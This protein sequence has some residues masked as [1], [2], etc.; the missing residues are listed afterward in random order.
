ML[1]VHPSVSANRGSLGDRTPNVAAAPRVSVVIP[2]YN[3]VDMLVSCLRALQA[4]RVARADYEVVVVDD[5]STDGTRDALREWT[6]SAEMALRACSRANGGP[7]AARNDGIRLARG[8]LIA[9]VDDDCLPEPDWLQ[10]LIAALPPD[11]RCAGIGGRIVGESNVLVARYV[12]WRGLSEHQRS[13][14]G[15]NY[16]V[17]ANA[18][19]HK[20]CL[21]EVGGFDERFRSAGGEDPELARR[22]RARGYYLMATERALVVHR[23]RETLR[24]FVDM[25]MR[26]GRGA[27]VDAQLCGQSVPFPRAR[28]LAFVA[29]GIGVEARTCLTRGHAAPIDRLAYLVL[30]IVWQLA[31]A[32]AYA[33]CPPIHSREPAER[34]LEGPNFRR[35]F[36]PL[37]WPIWRVSVARNLL[38]AQLS[39]KRE[40][41]PRAVRWIVR[42]LRYAMG[43]A[44]IR[45]GRR[46]TAFSILAGMHQ[47]DALES[48]SRLAERLARQLVGD[49]SRG[50]NSPNLCRDYASTLQPPSW[51]EGYF[52]DPC[53]ILGRLALVIKPRTER[54]KGVLVLK[55]NYTFSHIARFFDIDRISSAYHIVLEP[56]W[57]GYCN[58]AI[59]QYCSVCA[60]VFVEA[61]EPR[62]AAFIRTLGANLVAVPIASNWWVDHRVFRPLP[63]TRKDT[64]VVMVAT[65]ARYKRHFQFFR[66]LRDLRR[67]GR[68]LRVSLIGYPGDLTRHDVADMAAFFGV[69]GPD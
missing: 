42:W 23:H 55:Y 32:R 12:D 54:E 22:L 4:Q 24:G 64:D 35:P 27:G 19:F 36:G 56:A 33:S 26:Y 8:A 43:R 5:G 61:A 58:L 31:Y 60:P 53:T 15:I 63:G 30:G 49:V 39:E 34:L 67:K 14:E 47:A 48:A 37:R 11:A 28:V 21:L 69:C 17:T 66:V 46:S 59:L 6:P 18:L 9:F 50:G 3:R 51:A 40:Q 7:A 57:S 20:H 1:P 13:P 45:A 2:T 10:H 29:T 44:L 16:L 52:R 38:R 68:R 41:T 62:D 25:A 65:W